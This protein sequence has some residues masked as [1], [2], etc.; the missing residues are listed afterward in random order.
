MDYQNHASD[1]TG[2]AGESK[3]YRREQLC[4]QALEKID[5]N[6]DKTMQH[7]TYSHGK[8]HQANLAH[9]AAKQAKEAP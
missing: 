8:N 3:W 1:N 5:L 9:R 7:L 6:Q 4:Q 2:G